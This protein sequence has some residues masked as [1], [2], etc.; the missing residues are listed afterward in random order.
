MSELKR[1]DFLALDGD[2]PLADFRQHYHIPAGIIYMD[3]NSL[4]MMPKAVRPRLNNLLDQEWAEDLVTSWNKHQWFDLPYLVG[5]KIARIIGAESG[6]VVVTD[7]VSVN[8]FK[9][10]AAALKIQQANGRTV[11][12]SEKGNFPTDLYVLQGLTSM[13][14]VPVELITVERNDIAGAITEDTA[15]LLLTD[16]HYKTGHLLN[17]QAITELAHEKG[18]LVIWDLCHSAGALPIDLSALGA[19][20]AVGCG[21]KYLNGGPGAPAFLYVARRWQSQ[22]EQPLSGWWGHARPFDFSDDYQP[23]AGIGR[24]L[25][26]TQGVL[27]LAALEVAVDIFLTADMRQVR[28][29]SSLMG[30][31]FIQLLEQRCVGFNFELQSPRD[32]AQRG[33]Q[34]AIAHSHGYQIM[35]AMIASK[36]I[37]DFRAPNILRFGL[38]PLTLRYTDIWDAVT[39]LETIM[40]D[41]IWQQT[42]FAELSA[43]T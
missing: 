39:H 8:I 3:G 36:V 7:T 27:G 18:A 20:M 31:L 17:K 21:Y 25:C 34:I 32:A 29:K 15:V 9:L 42:R 14:G 19:D 35:Q 37:G 28:K 10:V 11:I 40:R 24:M 41:N 12:V 38:T 22:L 6:E 1:D 4:G 43:V 5:D 16:V 23:A 26:G 33:S 30:D 2:D 13:L